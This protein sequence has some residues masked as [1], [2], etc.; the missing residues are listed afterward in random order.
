MLNIVDESCESSTGMQ[1]YS[2]RFHDR[3]DREWLIILSTHYQQDNE[4]S[5]LSTR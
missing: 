3:V 1:K 5:I 4:Y 2:K